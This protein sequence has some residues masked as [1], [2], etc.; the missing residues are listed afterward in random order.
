MFYQSPLNLTT[1]QLVA[2]SRDAALSLEELTLQLLQQ[3]L[4]VY[5]AGSIMVMVRQAGPTLLMEAVLQLGTPGANWRRLVTGLRRLCR[6]WGCT[7]LQTSAT[8]ERVWE[9]VH[10]MGGHTVEQTLRME[11]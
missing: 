1:E 6:S 8:D 3:K 4:Q 7:H 11:I 2:L 5:V 9:L 10:R